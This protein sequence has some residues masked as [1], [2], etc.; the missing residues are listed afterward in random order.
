MEEKRM[1][2]LL[3]SNVW[4]DYF[5][6]KRPGHAD[7]VRLIGEA[8]RKDVTLLCTSFIMKDVFYLLGVIFKREERALAGSLSHDSAAAVN[9]AIW[10]CI[11]CMNEMATVVGSD[12]VDVWLAMKLRSVH[13]DLEDDLVVAAAKRAET[14][15][16]VTNDERLIK[17]APVAALMPADALAMVA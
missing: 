17:H 16:L 5:I 15:Y 8:C 14:T 2:L 4:L 12:A 10:G 1:S 11:R 7:A 13:G 9:E 3:D 6:A